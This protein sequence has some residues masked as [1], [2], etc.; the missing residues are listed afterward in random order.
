MTICKNKSFVSVGN[1]YRTGG[2]EFMAVFF[3]KNLEELKK[4]NKVLARR[5]QKLT[6][7]EASEHIEVYEAESK[8]LI[9][10]LLANAAKNSISYQMQ[11]QEVKNQN[12]D[13]TNFEDD[14]NEFKANFSRNVDLAKDKF[15]KSI[16][17]IDKTIDH[18]QKVK[19][20]LLSSERN[21]RLAND[22]AQELTIKKL[23]HGN[24]TMKEMFNE[25]K[26]K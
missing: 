22:K 7:E 11:L 13:I 20:G 4:K 12:I 2:D 16:E 10:T 18:L 14:L 3:K 17:E 21:L 8:D 25:A 9:I 24:P 26:K 6:L 19:E 23:T 1:S 5:L 15:N